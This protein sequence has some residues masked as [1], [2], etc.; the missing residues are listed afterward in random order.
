MLYQNN[1]PEKNVNFM[2]EPYASGIGQT[3]QK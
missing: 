1:F 3:M 2:R